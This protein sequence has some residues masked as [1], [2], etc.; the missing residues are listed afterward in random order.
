MTNNLDK[1]AK[2]SLYTIKTG[3]LMQKYTFKLIKRYFS[4][5]N[6]VLELGPAEGVMT[7]LLVN[8]FDSVELLEGSS[9]FCEKLKKKTSR[10]CCS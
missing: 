3:V 10:N 5:N 6:S 7:Q 1:I 9:F 4:K 2:N 8:Y